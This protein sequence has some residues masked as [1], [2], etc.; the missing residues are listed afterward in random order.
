MEIRVTTN[1]PAA[2]AAI[3]ALPHRTVERVF[4]A[5]TAAGAA[6][7]AGVK[8]RAAE[9]RTAAR[10]GA[11]GGTD[12]PRLLTGNYNRSIGRRTVVGATSITATVGTNAP[13]G[14]RL[15]FG[16]HGTDAAGRTF[17]QRA[18]PHFGPALDEVRPAFEAAVLEALT[19]PSETTP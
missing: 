14:R 11:A 5:V 2:V 4:E 10:P 19:D 9:P 16:F 1:A 7:Q 18:Y 6:L 15:E 12:G 3:G 17:D 8:R 13:Q